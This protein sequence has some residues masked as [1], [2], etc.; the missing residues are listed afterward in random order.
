M[1]T[2]HIPENLG[3]YIEWRRK[4]LGMSRRYLCR[5]MGYKH[6]DYLYNVERCS[7]F[8]S[9]KRI[10]LLAR[11]LKVREIEIVRRA[12][13]YEVHRIMKFYGLRTD[14]LFPEYVVK[15]K[16]VKRRNL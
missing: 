3:P 9:R 11:E 15:I 13:L 8:P 5:A 7:R 14:G 4:Q 16:K 12:A 2:F 1:V 10:K 6:P